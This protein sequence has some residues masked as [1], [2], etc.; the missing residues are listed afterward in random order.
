MR[1]PRE[2]TEP[3][4]KQFWPWFLI[5]LP[6]TAVLASIITITLAV[7]SR[8]GLVHDDYYQKGLAIHKDAAQAQAARS[9]GIEAE[10]RYTTDPSAVEVTFNDSAI[11]D[12][13]L[14]TLIAVHPTR[15]HQDQQIEIRRTTP[16]SYVG[17]LPTL[18]PANWH[19]SIQPPSRVWRI[20]G[21]IAIPQSSLARL[22]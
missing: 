8:D 6:A 10:L 13:P 4:H 21:R 22:N 3:W 11:G 15:S 20:D 17:A 1:P 19:V 12:P 9:L 7:K 14:L 5:A 18:A 16:G 2:D